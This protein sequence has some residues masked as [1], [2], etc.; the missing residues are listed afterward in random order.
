MKIKYYILLIISIML[1]FSNNTY[2]QTYTDPVNITDNQKYYISRILMGDIDN[3][4]TNSANKYTYYNNSTTSVNKNTNYTL[5]ISYRAQKWNTYYIKIWIDYNNDGDFIDANEEIFALTGTS[6]SN[7]SVSESFNFTIPSGAATETTRMRAAIKHNSGAPTPQDLGYQ[8]GE[9]EDYN[10]NILPVPTPPT[11]ICLG[12]TLNVNLD[13][14]G[15]ATI[16]PSQINNGSYDDYD[17]PENLTYSLSKSSFNCN[18]IGN[19]TVTLTVTDSNGLTDTCTATVNVSAYSGAFTAPTLP[20]INTYCSYTATAP[21]MDYQCGQK[22]TATTTD[23]TTLTSSGTI[24]WSFFNGSTTETSVQTINITTPTTPTTVTISSITETTA[25]ISWNAVNSGPFKIRYRPV[26]NTTWSQTTSTNKFI[27]LSG[28]DNGTQY[29]VQVA[30]NAS[31]ASYSASTNFTTIEV[32][33]CNN[34]VA[35]N[36]NNQYYISQTTIGDINQSS[37]KNQGPYNYYNGVS[38]TVTAGQNI[39]GTVVYQKNQNNTAGF[40]IWIDYNQ[41]G[42]FETPGEVVYSNL[43]SGTPPIVTV[44]ETFSETIPTTASSGK[45]RMRVVMLHNQIPT[46]ACTYNQNGDIEDYDIYIKPVPTPPTAVCIESINLNLDVAGNLTITPDQIDNGSYDDFDVSGDLTLSLDKTTFTCNDLGDNTVILTVTDTDGLTDTCTATVNIAPF[47]G[48]FTAPALDD[49]DAFCTYTATAPVMDYLCGTQITATTSDNTTL[50]SSGTITW[51]F[52]NGSTTAQSVQTINI[53]SPSTPT[54]VNITNIT[55]TTATVNWEA[56]D[57]T[58]FII[59]YKETSESIWI[60]TTSTTTS[61]EL[62]A[63][64]NGSEYEVRVS[65]DVDPACSSTTTSAVTFETI[66]IE[67]CDD[68]NVNINLNTNYFISNTNVNSGDINQTTSNNSGPYQYFDGTSTTVTAGGTLSATITYQ[69]ENNADTGFTVWIDFNHDGDFEDSG[70]EIYSNLTTSSGTQVIETLSNINI[71]ITATTGKTRI[72]FAMLQD[73]TPISPC[74]YSNKAGDIEDYDIYIDPKDT[75]SFEAAMITQVYHTELGERWIEITNKSTST[76]ATN[77]L[78]VALFQNT[79]GDQTGIIPTATYTVN[80]SLAS[81]ATTLIKSNTSSINVSPITPLDNNNVT[82]F[83]NGDDIIAIVSEVGTAAWENRFDVVSNVTN[84]TSYVRNDEIL[85][86]NNT[87]TAS[88]WTA[89][90]NDNLN[91]YRDEENGG[92][93]RHP[94]APLLSEVTFAENTTNAKLGVHNFGATTMTSNVWDNGTPDRSRYAII[95]QDYEETTNPIKARK[96]NITN[97]NKLTITDQLLI[98]TNN[99][100]VNTTAEIRLAG[101]SQLIQTHTGTKQLTGTG[102]YYIDRNVNNPSIYRFSYFS[103]PMNSIGE[104]TFTLADVLKD[105]TIPT[106]ST[107]SAVDINF[108][109][110]YDGAA[111]TPISIA[112]HW[113][114]TYKSVTGSTGDYVQKK[115]LE[116]IQQTDG[117]TMKGTGVAQNY[118]YVGIP[119]D[120]DLTTSIAGYESYL[121]GNPYPSAISAKKFIEDNE[122]AI[123]G[124]LYFWQHVGE[125]STS[126]TA[127][128]NYGGYIGGYAT[129]NKTMGV[130]A[131]NVASNSN[132]YTGTTPEENSL[133]TA[134]KAYIAVGQAFFIQGDID[135]G[136][137]T[138]NNSQ[139]EYIQEGSESVFFKVSTDKNYMNKTSKI[140][141]IVTLEKDNTI[142]IIKLGMNFKNEENNNLH[143][144]IGVSFNPNNSFAY[145]EGYDSESFN[146]GATDI[147]WKFPS[148]EEK[149]AIAGVQEISD[150]LEIPLEIKMGYDGEITLNIDEWKSVNRDVYL[151]DKV[152]NTATKINGEIATLNLSQNTYSDRFYLAFNNSGTLDGNNLISDSFSITY[153][154]KLHLIKI[155]NTNNISINTIDLYSIIGQQINTWTEFENNSEIT[156]T[157]GNIAPNIY[158]IKVYTNKGVIKKK[159]FIQKL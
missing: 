84:N 110:G 56:T 130:A 3:S 63:L 46:D 38:T 26:G 78:I 32:E 150:D 93:E 8:N 60:Q 122:D 96:L 148:D 103:S 75:S 41:N 118:T 17:A 50:T 99:I 33:Y 141:P 146:T 40:I 35:I 22:I 42:E 53:S 116:Y 30:I 24:T 71:P 117:F 143:K 57:D 65:L 2:A 19:N 107:S 4:S 153:N 28:L 152:N 95:N 121:V 14:S 70:E 13:V 114:Y 133:Y 145:D 111:T 127:G 69:K 132:I 109:S 73:Q 11:A 49:V 80:T 123:T 76:I 54:N 25:K 126:G 5:T 9:V 154:K 102:K 29:E 15:T 149:Y 1:F 92:P 88:E 157:P 135:G 87:Y 68:N 18:N 48:A 66:A 6:N 91:P 31:C 23:N 129:R 108:V 61:V 45:T 131:D 83:D 44:T 62:T 136:T 55:E 100:N 89:F 155:A 27:N 94:N 52:D 140:L 12:T 101:T 36:Q 39:S 21:V 74:N 120:G 125:Q 58:D 64:N 86:Y 134:P 10:I 115:S 97:N 104:T 106:S 113:I 138:F 151:K 112:E 77:T 105:G 34:S 85:T 37:S 59:E 159:L 47:A 82:A 67:Y 81:G 144:Q 98:V 137:V 128:H 43:T 7:S 139:R 72:R 79:S 16:T 158:I 124:T 51:T 142:P 119:K 90:V 156:L 20:T 147:Y